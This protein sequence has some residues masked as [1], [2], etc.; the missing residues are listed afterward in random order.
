M[1]CRRVSK[2]DLYWNLFSAGIRTGGGSFEKKKEVGYC[3]VGES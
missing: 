3:S 1:P 2:G